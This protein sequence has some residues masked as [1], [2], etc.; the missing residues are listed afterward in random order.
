[1]PATMTSTI[2]GERA[3]GQAEGE[4]VDRREIVDGSTLAR[5]YASSYSQY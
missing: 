2:M 5:L 1:M 4:L 3:T